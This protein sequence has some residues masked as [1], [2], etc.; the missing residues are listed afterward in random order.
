MG[1]YDRDYVRASGDDWQD[2]F[3]AGRGG[4]P[5]SRGG[6][7]SATR[8]LVFANIAMFVVQ[9]FSRN[10][11]R[12]DP[13]LTPRLCLDPERPWEVWRL[14]TGGFCHDIT[15]L[16][17]LLF[18]MIILWWA[19]REVE[20]RL[21]YR[22]MLAYYLAAEVTCSLTYLA[23]AWIVGSNAPAVGG[24]GAVMAVLVL[25]AL[26]TPHLTVMVFHVLPMEVA[27][28][29]LAYVAFDAVPL[30]DEWFSHRGTSV[31]AH[32]GRLGGAVFALAYFRWAP[33]GSSAPRS[34]S[35]SWVPKWLRRVFRRTPPV[36]SP[37]PRFTLVEPTPRDELELE[38]DRLL[39]KIAA[40]GE[41][42]LSP[43]ERV[44]LVEASRRYREK[45]GK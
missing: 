22:R 27:W 20:A 24:A 10:P 37:A 19:G 8:Q 31:V 36:A 11:S 3:R 44:T 14:V 43:E 42:S 28:V 18:A 12:M 4:G 45:Q 35:G 21:G 13:G 17:S 33:S 29:A 1:L 5:R 16:W 15:S 40:A 6:A 9:L 34:R 26:H 7:R 23:Y 25:L 2:R 32:A 39:A 38:V 41:E 30:A